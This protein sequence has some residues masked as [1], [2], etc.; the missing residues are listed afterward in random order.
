MV[1][2]KCQSLL[3]YFEEAKN[4]K[5]VVSLVNENG[6]SLNVSYIEKNSKRLNSL[7]LRLFL[8]KT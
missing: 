8:K 6:I 2:L 3:A 5:E 7:N 4:T 1:R